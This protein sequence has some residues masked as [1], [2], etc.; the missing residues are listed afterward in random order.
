MSKIKIPAQQTLLKRKC[1]RGTMGKRIKQVLY[2]IQGLCLTLSKKKL[3]HKFSCPPKNNHAQPKAEEKKKHSPENCPPHP[4]PP[5]IPQ[6]DNGS[7][8]EGLPTFITA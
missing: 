7:S 8:L 6:K 5:P 3:L 2:T 1:V 4:H